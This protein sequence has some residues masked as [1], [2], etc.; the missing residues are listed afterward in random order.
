MTLKV[1][2][3]YVVRTLSISFGFKHPNVMRI[4]G[5]YFLIF[6]RNT[7]VL[8]YAIV[9]LHLNYFYFVEK[10]RIILKHKNDN[11]NLSLMSKRC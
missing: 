5:C 9:R 11:V 1:G 6:T 7:N 10:G 3:P 2:Y 8:A 4:V